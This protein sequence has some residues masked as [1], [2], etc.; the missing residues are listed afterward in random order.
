MSDTPMTDA[1]IERAFKEGDEQDALDVMEDFARDL[2]RV[3]AKM[4]EALPNAI[5]WVNLYHNAPADAMRK[6]AEIALAAWRELQ[7]RY[8]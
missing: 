3:A 4:V 7:E 6:Q 8:K 1:R 5:S 2:E